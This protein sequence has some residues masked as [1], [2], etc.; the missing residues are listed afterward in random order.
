MYVYAMRINNM[1]VYTCECI[2]IL[3]C[4]HVRMH[5]CV[6]AQLII[7]NNIKKSTVAQVSLFSLVRLPKPG[8]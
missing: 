4:A 5:V 1:C 2:C 6:Y 3:L 7:T 8:P